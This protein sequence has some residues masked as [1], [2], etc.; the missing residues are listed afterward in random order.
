MLGN[1][2]NLDVLSMRRPNWPARSGIPNNA[3]ALLVF[4]MKTGPYCPILSFMIY[5]L[6]VGVLKAIEWVRPPSRYALRKPLCRLAIDLSDREM[7]DPWLLWLLTQ[8]QM[9]SSITTLVVSI[10]CMSNQAVMFQRLLS[11]VDSLQHLKILVSTYSCPSISTPLPSPPVIEHQALESLEIQINR[12]GSKEPQLWIPRLWNIL[13]IATSSHL[14]II[15]LAMDIDMDEP[16]LDLVFKRLIWASG[17][18]HSSSIELGD[19]DD[20]LCHLPNL[21][22]L[23]VS[24]GLVKTQLGRRGGV[25]EEAMERWLKGAFW[26]CN[27]K[28]ILNVKAT[29]HSVVKDWE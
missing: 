10:M 28:D 29:R 26:Q 20:Y 23:S 6:L 7:D 11:T 4:A 3:P 21:R 15:R 12:Y 14:A 2:P 25:T 13:H 1:M 8:T 27:A 17:E 16:E 19:I 24:V 5:K 18:V 9:L 22:Q